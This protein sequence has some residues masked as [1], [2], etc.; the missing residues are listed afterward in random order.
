MNPFRI[1]DKVRHVYHFPSNNEEFIITCLDEDTI[2]FVCPKFN[3]FSTIENGETPFF[4]YVYYILIPKR[5]E[6]ARKFRIKL[7]KL[8]NAREIKNTFRIGDKIRRFDNLKNTYVITC[9]RDE[10]IGYVNKDIKVENDIKEGRKPWFSH[11][12][13]ELVDT[14]E[15]LEFQKKIK[16]L[17]D[18]SV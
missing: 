16:E 18:E 2:G 1:G 15:N 6:L 8:L 11:L 9:I 12:F 7:L 17:V 4:H 14:K 13:Y 3:L 10:L 5:F